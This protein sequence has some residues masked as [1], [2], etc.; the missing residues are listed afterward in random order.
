MFENITSVNYEGKYLMDTRGISTHTVFFHAQDHIDNCGDENENQEI[1]FFDLVKKGKFRYVIDYGMFCHHI[2]YHT[3]RESRQKEA[4]LV[5][6]FHDKIFEVFQEVT[7][8]I[9][10]KESSHT[11]KVCVGT[12]WYSDNEGGK[13]GESELA[14]KLFTPSYLSEIFVPRIQRSLNPRAIHIY[15]SE[16]ETPLNPI[17][18]GCEVVKGKR[19]AKR[20]T[21][22]GEKPYKIGAAHDW[23]AAMMTGAMFAFV[24]NLNYFFVE[25]DCLVHNFKRVYEISKEM[26]APIIYGFGGLS[27]F[28]T[29]WAEP[30]LTFVN[31]KFLQE[32][33]NRL[34]K[35]LWHEWNMGF[36]RF[37][38]PERQFHNTFADVAEY[39]PF[40]YGMKR[41]IDWSKE[42]FFAQRFDTL[43][44]ETFISKSEG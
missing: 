9:F 28:I 4:E 15:A 42:V 18:E 19:I 29:G 27:S 36:E 43:N 44:F 10:H 22:I 5:N 33:M 16:C 8:P 24:N 14:E 21:T 39:W 12:G 40:G 41:P 35:G 2:N 37:A 32:F 3:I 34:C 20:N 7:F 6:A 38:N 25:Q 23:G 13:R 11:N 31:Y 17:P 30:S 1:R 26:G